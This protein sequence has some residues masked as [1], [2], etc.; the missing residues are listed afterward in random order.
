MQKVLLPSKVLAI[1]LQQKKKKITKAGKE[2]HI[3]NIE[4]DR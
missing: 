1:E 4:L 3:M 2:T